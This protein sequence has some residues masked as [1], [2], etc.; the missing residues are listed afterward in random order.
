MNIRIVIAALWLTPLLSAHCD[1]MDG[2]VVQ[3]AR[4][5]LAAGDV[6]LV[7]PWVQQDKEPGIRAAFVQAMKVRALDSAA[8]KLADTWFFETLVRV[9]R[10]GEGAPY[11]GLKADAS[12][13]GPALLAA[14]K[15]I[16]S[17]DLQGLE[18][19]LTTAVSQG[20]RQRFARVRDAQAHAAHSV[21]AGRQYVA[22]YVEFIHF[23]EGVEK[24]LARAGEHAKEHVH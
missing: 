23:A 19:T 20:L 10:A 21:E 12:A 18:K 4:R 11:D 22:A 15:A 13:F 8:Q 16:A 3:A 5:A 9:H 17:G 1:S 14:D 7:L 6:K 24:A 2:P